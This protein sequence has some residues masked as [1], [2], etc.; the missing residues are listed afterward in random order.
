MCEKVC[1]YTTLNII[2]SVPSSA[3]ILVV[4]RVPVGDC[5]Y[6]AN[7]GKWEFLLKQRVFLSVFVS[8]FLSVFEY[9][10]HGGCT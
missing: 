1:S 10:S 5:T 6:L 3:D 7:T 9:I 4:P 8:V 2:R